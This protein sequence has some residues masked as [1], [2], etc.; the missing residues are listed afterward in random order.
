MANSK[1][2]IDTTILADVLLKT[3]PAHDAA[4]QA[5]ASYRTTILPV[6]AIKEWK[7]S[8]FNTYVYIHN[9]L[10][11][12]NSFSQ[13]NH[14][15]SRL[16]M[17]SRMQSTAFEAMAAA[18][19][20][21]NSTPGTASSD[22]ELAERFRLIFKTLIYRSWRARRS[23]ATQTVMDLDCYVETG[24]KLQPNGDIDIHPRDC[25][26][27][28]ECCL[29]ETLRKKKDVLQKLREAIPTTVRPEDT[30]RRQILRH[31]LV[32]PGRRM[33][34][35]DCRALGDAYF[36]FFAPSDADILTTNLKDHRPLAESVGKTAVTP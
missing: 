23:V 35:E 16:F 15:L 32:H 17:R 26:D 24:P 2:F 31:L 34:R 28:R 19:I 6:F 5:L 36:A 9:L 3:G 13:T 12:T 18:S 27:E 10:R 21:L 4:L 11:Q 20:L 25:G 29:A 30:K 14:R 1:A 33:N 8:Q 22:A 7:R